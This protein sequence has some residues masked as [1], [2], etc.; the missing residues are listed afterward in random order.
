MMGNM[1]EYLKKYGGRHLDEMPLNDVDLMIFAQLSYCDF[2]TVPAGATLCEAAQLLLHTEKSMDHTEWRFSFQQADD[3]ALLLWIAGS[4][5]YQQAIVRAFERKYDEENMQFAALGL[6]LPGQGVIAYRGTDNTLAGWKEDFD[7]CFRMPVAAQE[8]A[9]RFYQ[10]MAA[11]TDAPFV[12]C[13]HSKGGGLAL[14]AGLFGEDTLKNRVTR[15]VSFDGV[16]LPAEALARVEADPACAQ[17]LSRTRVML[18][19]GSVVGVIFPQ[20]GQVRTVDCRR[21]SLMQHYL[22]NWV[23][24]GT[25]FVDSERTLMSRAAAI[26]IDEFLSQLSLSEREQVIALLYEI[27]RTTKAQTFEDILRGWIKNTVPVAKAVLEKLDTETAKL[28]LKVVTSF[29]RALAR[30]AGVLISGE[31]EANETAKG[32]EHNE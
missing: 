28:Y 22:F 25:D 20:P 6:H 13:G 18:P 8:E 30:T 32:T 12:L 17:V 29:Y 14:Y 5:R 24:E 16:G 9:L 3:E 11:E 4:A 7:L 21:V 1:L 19:E 10:R 26:A 23:I 2:L 27:I 31:E 15:L